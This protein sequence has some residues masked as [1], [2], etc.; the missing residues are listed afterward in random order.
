MI[1]G[2][3]TGFLLILSLLLMIAYSLIGLFNETKSRAKIMDEHG[4]LM[5]SALEEPQLDGSLTDLDS[6]M[7]FQKSENILQ[8]FDPY[9]KGLDEV[10]IHHRTDLRRGLASKDKIWIRCLKDIEEFENIFLHELGH[11]VARNYLSDDLE[12]KFYNIGGVSVSNYGSERPEEDFAESFLMYIKRG[13]E[14]RHILQ[15]NKTLESKYIF[16]RDNIF[17]GYEFELGKALDE[18][19]VDKYTRDS[20]YPYDISV[21]HKR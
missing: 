3:Y 9:T 11:I 14:F 1:E 12:D 4:I 19:I 2:K 16:I 21:L 20:T 10:T 8:K 15:D 7:C 17:D 5:L 18:G 13:E 6:D